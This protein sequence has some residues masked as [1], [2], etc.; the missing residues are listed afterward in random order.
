M[1]GYWEVPAGVLDHDARL[2]EW[3]RRAIDAARRAPARRKSKRSAGRAAT[4]ARAPKAR[5]RRR[6]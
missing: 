5:G 6:A 2:V 1:G 4:P 3:A